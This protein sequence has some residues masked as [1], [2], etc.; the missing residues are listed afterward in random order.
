MKT[1]QLLFVLMALLLGMTG[2]NHANAGNTYTNE[3]GTVTWTVGNESKPTI[4]DNVAG[5]I[6]SYNALVAAVAELRTQA[7][8]DQII[9][10]YE[11]NYKSD[12]NK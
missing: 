5:A 8:A 10:N 7:Y 2:Y 11:Q 4:S 3:S 1:K 9:Y 12:Y 6:S